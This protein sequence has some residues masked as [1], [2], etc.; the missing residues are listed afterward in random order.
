MVVLAASLGGAVGAP[1]TPVYLGRPAARG[2]QPNR[3][4][5]DDH[6]WPPHPAR[7]S[8]ADHRALP[9]QQLVLITVAAGAGLTVGVAVDLDVQRLPQDHL[10]FVV[11]SITVMITAMVTRDLALP[12][13]SG[14]GLV[15]LLASSYLSYYLRRAAPGRCQARR[16]SSATPTMISWPAL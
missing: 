2:E 7:H 12:A 10:P 5:V 11:H 6:R 16:A 15:A 13:P 8:P 14:G 9:G 1:A 3:N 4:R